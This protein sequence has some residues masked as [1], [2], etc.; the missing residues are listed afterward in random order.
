MQPND[1]KSSVW[2]F[3]ANL[4][5]NYLKKQQVMPD[6]SLDDCREA[7]TSVDEFVDVWGV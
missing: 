6:T 1:L 3:K 4:V 2:K 5:E 7:N